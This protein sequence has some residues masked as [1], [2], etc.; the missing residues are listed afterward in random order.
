MDYHFT[1][2]Q[3]DLQLMTR[4]FAEKELIPIAAEYDHKSEFPMEAFKKAV[5]MGL[6]CLD[7]PEEWGGAG[8]DLLTT[9]LIREELSRGDAGFSSAVGAC[10]LGFKP[11]N[12]AGTEEQKRKYADVVTGGGLLALGLTEPNA[13]SDVASNKTT[14]VKKG[15]KYIL[16]GRKCFITNAPLADIITIFAVTD[17]EA[18]AKG[19]SMFMVEK[20]AP[21]LSIGKHEDKLGIRSSATADVIMEDCEIPASALIGREGDGFKIVMQTLDKGRVCAGASALGVARAALEHSVRYAQERIQKGKPIWKHQI[22]QAK[23]ADMG[24][25][26][27]AARQLVW[28]AAMA[29]D[30]EAKD[31]AKLASM[32]KCFAGDMVV[33]LTCEALQIHG[34]YGYSREYP[35]EKLYRDAKIFQIFE[36]TNEIQRTIIAKNMVDEQR[37][38]TR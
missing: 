5:T 7:L 13:G 19:F 1:S 12:F 17:K 22:I 10:G 3:I 34:G 37:I 14:A 24:M 6:T 15:D 25:R 11:I 9:A 38:V 21:G 32:C 4:E 26:L 20:G 2:D 30:A 16:N 27:E 35:I 31:T 33:Y 36:G 8:V 23:L 29:F 18:G 28:R